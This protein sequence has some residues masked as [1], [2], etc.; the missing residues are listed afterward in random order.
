MAVFILKSLVVAAVAGVVVTFILYLVK[1]LLK[2]AV[3][4]VHMWEVPLGCPDHIRH[5]YR[6][7]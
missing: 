5:H 4:D 2:A 3:Q 1:N 7:D 6:T